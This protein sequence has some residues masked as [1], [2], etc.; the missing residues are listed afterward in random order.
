MKNE[1]PLFLMAELAEIGAHGAKQELRKLC[2]EGTELA[3]EVVTNRKVIDSRVTLTKAFDYWMIIDTFAGVV[4][5]FN[6]KHYAPI[7]VGGH[8]ILQSKKSG[9]KTTVYNGKELD[10][11]NLPF[12]FTGGSTLGSRNSKSVRHYFTKSNGSKYNYK[13]KVHT[14]VAAVQLGYAVISCVGESRTHEIHHLDHNHKNNKADNL[15][16]LKLVEHKSYHAKNRKK[17]VV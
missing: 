2:K 8:L 10:F 11:Q 9:V 13:L 12:I 7:V 5:R 3:Y 16:I 17:Q 14:I 1:T 6:E 15:T 4:A